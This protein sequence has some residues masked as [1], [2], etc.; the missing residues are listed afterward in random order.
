MLVPGLQYFLNFANKSEPRRSIYI[1]DYGIDSEEYYNFIYVHTYFI[2]IL[3]VLILVNSETI[4][5]ASVQ[6]TCAIL[7]A[8]G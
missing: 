3:V 4:L 1:T 8:I 7:A 5:M 2:S 6:H